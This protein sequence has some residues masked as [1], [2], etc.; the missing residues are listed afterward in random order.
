MKMNGR[1]DFMSRVQ[2]FVGDY[3]V[4]EGGIW[5]TW[6]DGNRTFIN[7]GQVLKAEGRVADD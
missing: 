5:V 6:K 2:H 4:V 7:Q 1:V 3:E